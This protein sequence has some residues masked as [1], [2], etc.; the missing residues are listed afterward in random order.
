[1]QF[2]DKVFD[3][4]TPSQF[5]ANLVLLLIDTQARAEPVEHLD[6]LGRTFR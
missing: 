2:F 4:D 3:G 1:M 5:A 6:D